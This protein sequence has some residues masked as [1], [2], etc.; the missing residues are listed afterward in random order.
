MSY[1]MTSNRRNRTAAV[2]IL[3]AGF[4]LSSCSG[5]G[6]RAPDT[7]EPGEEDA[8]RLL[9]EISHVNDGLNAFKGI[10]KIRL[11]HENS[12]REARVAWI[13][14][15]NGKLRLEI[16]SFIGQPIASLASDGQWLYIHSHA[17]Q[18]FHKARV[19]DTGLKSLIDIPISSQDVIDFL[20]GRTPVRS[21]RHAALL[22]D[23]SRPGVI[24]ELKTR[25]GNV[26]E[27]IYIHDSRAAVRKVEMFDRLKSLVYGAVFEE[28]SEVDGFSVPREM[29]IFTGK[30][31]SVRLSVEKYWSNVPVSPSMFVLQRP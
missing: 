3:L 19:S 23:A 7:A 16:L 26:L 2:F 5:W 30:G 31:T 12:L 17:R 24:L 11:T 27:R 29:T 13:G 22:R 25:W 8:R 18:R 28:M 20:T 21:Y 1:R 9:S 10:G 6:G 15:T 4:F 14:A